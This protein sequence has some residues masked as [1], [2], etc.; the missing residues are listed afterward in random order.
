MRALRIAPRVW[1]LARSCAL[2]RFAH[3]CD[4]GA[5]S[6]TAC[7]QLPGERTVAQ[8]LA[9]TA[10]EARRPESSFGREVARRAHDSDR[11]EVQRRHSSRSA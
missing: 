11:Q 7:R 2:P 3:P 6:P 4:L 8:A 10:V 5:T 9:I 1:R